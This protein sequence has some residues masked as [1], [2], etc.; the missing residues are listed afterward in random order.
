MPKNLESTHDL[1]KIGAPA[2]RALVNAGYTNLEGLADV[3][4]IELLKLHGMGPKAIR[5]LREALEELGLS[6]A[7]HWVSGEKVL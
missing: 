5:L 6:F 7:D 3:S 2:K 1:P 4:E